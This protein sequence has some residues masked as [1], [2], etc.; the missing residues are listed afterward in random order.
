MLKYPS[1]IEGLV[2][3]N[4]LTGLILCA[5]CYMKDL[6]QTFTEEILVAIAFCILCCL[7]LIPHFEKM[8]LRLL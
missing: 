2:C 7:Q 3:Y 8:S 6:D 5:V 1:P 4:F